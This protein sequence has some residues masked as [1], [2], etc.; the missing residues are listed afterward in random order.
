VEGGDLENVRRRRRQKDKVAE[1]V[2]E[3]VEEEEAGKRLW[4]GRRGG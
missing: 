1:E 3:E 2:E 4:R